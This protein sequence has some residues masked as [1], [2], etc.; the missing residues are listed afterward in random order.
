MAQNDNRDW[1]M[2]RETLLPL[3]LLGLALGQAPTVQSAE[4]ASASDGKFH[5]IYL[6]S[7]VDLKPGSKVYVDPIFFTDGKEVKNFH[8][9]CKPERRTLQPTQIVGDL[10][11][12]ENYCAKKTFSFDPKDYHTLNNHG[13]RVTL[14]RVGFHIS[15]ARGVNGETVMMGYSKLES[16]TPGTIV[17]PRLLRNDGAPEY[18]FLMAKHRGLLTAILPMAKAIAAD[19]TSLIERAR[20]FADASKGKAENGEYA[21]L[22]EDFKP[23]VRRIVANPLFAD[24]DDDGSTDLVV[25]IEARFQPVEGHSAPDV[26][27]LSVAYLTAAGRNVLGYWPEFFPMGPYE[28]LSESVDGYARFLSNGYPVMTP[29]VVVRL[30]R[31]NY[32][33]RFMEDRSMPVPHGLHLEHKPNAGNTEERCRDIRL[34]KLA[35]PM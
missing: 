29:L 31:C 23:I 17:P 13:E 22:R 28:R 2:R 15:D 30:N 6:V 26:R 32:V 25:G 24:V 21:L 19:M 5:L 33:L 14:E 4:P 16:F 8:D 20:Q 11:F 12:I 7:A 34:T 10:K 27:W 35:V 1:M 3:L 9:H 18:F